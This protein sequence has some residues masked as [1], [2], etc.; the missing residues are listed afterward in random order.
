MNQVRY[1]PSMNA[2]GPVI[3]ADTV[4]EAAPAPRVNGDGR[5][6]WHPLLADVFGALDTASVTWCLLR[7]PQRPDAPDGDVDLLVDPRHRAVLRGALEALGFARIPNGGTPD[8][9]YLSYDP[10]GECWVWLHVTSEVSFGPRLER[11]SGAASTCLGRRTAVGGAWHLAAEDEFWVT[12][13]HAALDK[14]TFSE[15]HRSRLVALARQLGVEGLRASA[16]LGDAQQQGAAT[17]ALE[18]LRQDRWDDLLA[19]AEAWTAG[20][21]DSTPW[22]R[23]RKELVQVARLA[24]NVLN[25]WRRRGIS[26]AL[27]GPDGAGK[28]TLAEGLK[29]EFFF[30]TRSYYM[31]VK[32]EELRSVARLRVPGLTFAVYLTTLWRRLAGARWRQAHGELVVFDRYKYD[33]MNATDEATS[34]TKALARWVHTRLF[35]SAGMALVLNLPGEQ[36][37]SRKGERSPE[38]LEDERRRWLTMGERVPNLHVIDASQPAHRVRADA[39]ALIWARYAAR[40]R[41][42]GGRPTAAVPTNAR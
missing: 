5:E 16:V 40:W 9:F 19:Y 8:H 21:L 30:P 14:G 2:T 24:R 34:H 13:L 25:P 39:I 26:V 27:L 36:M 1:S 10:A 35:P 4:P 6:G 15:R 41:R 7:S 12:L 22:A 32:A 33:A 18:A 11:R 3:P 28:S 17:E 42:A 29:E 23:A 31:D 38:E 37:F 20:W